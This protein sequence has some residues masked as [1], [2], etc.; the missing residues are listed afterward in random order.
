[1]VYGNGKKGGKINIQW[2]LDTWPVSQKWNAG[3]QPLNNN[4]NKKKV[5]LSSWHFCETDEVWFSELFWG[6]SFQKRKLLSTMSPLKILRLIRSCKTFYISKLSFV[7]PASSSSSEIDAV[8]K[9]LCRNIDRIH[10]STTSVAA[11]LCVS[12]PI[13]LAHP[14]LRSAW[15]ASCP[16]MRPHGYQAHMKAIKSNSNQIQIG[17]VYLFCVRISTAK[18]EWALHS[19]V[20]H[21]LGWSFSK[22]VCLCVLQRQNQHAECQNKCW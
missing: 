13:W 9:Y 2:L 15:T 7:F 16:T 21:Q 5:P 12:S 20:T 11:A 3:S 17:F 19:Q 1:M 8:N 22:R 18:A 6:I 10:A 14:S 4:N